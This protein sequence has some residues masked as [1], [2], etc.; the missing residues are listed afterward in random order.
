MNSAK[1]TA[2]AIGYQCVFAYAVS[3]IIYQL[4]SAFTGKVNVVGLIAAVAVI[5]FGLYMLVRPNK[6]AQKAKKSK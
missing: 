6:Y 5:L 2:F 4:G 1:W 3:L